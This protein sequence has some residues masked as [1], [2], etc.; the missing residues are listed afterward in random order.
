LRILRL[1]GFNSTYVGEPFKPVLKNS[2]Y[3]EFL[4]EY[5][6]LKNKVGFLAD[7]DNRFS[8]NKSSIKVIGNQ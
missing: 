4:W 7:L 6:E 8:L 5:E 3:L 1:I 2:N